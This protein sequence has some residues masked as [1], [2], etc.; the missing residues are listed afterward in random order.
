VIGAASNHVIARG[1]GRSYGD[2]A[3]TGGGTVIDNRGLVQRSMIDPETGTITLG[4]GVSLDELLR[5]AIPAGY[6]VPVTPGTRQV[7]IGGAIAAD[8]HGKN[9]HVDGSFMD[10]IEALT[11]VTPTGT[12]S[13]SPS[14]DPE[15]F[16]AT[17]GGM[18][19]TGVVVEATLRLMPIET[20]SVLVDTERFDDLDALMDAMVTGDHRYRYS[21]AWVD[22]MTKGA[23]LGRGVLTRGD[24]A[25]ADQVPLDKPRLTPPGAPKL[26]IPF[27]APKGLLNKFSIAA[28]NEAWFRKAPKHRDAEIQ[29]LSTFFHPLDGVS[30]WNRLH[31]PRGFLQ[32]QFVVPDSASAVVRQSMELLSSRSVPS[33]LAVLKRFGEGNSGLLSF[34]SA[35]W[36]LALDIPLGA[37][38][39][40]AVLDELDD[41]IA[42]AGGRIYLAKDSRLSP[43]LIPTMYP[44]FEQFQ[45]VCDRVDPAQK[46]GSD[47]SRRLNLRG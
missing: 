12:F 33:F 13:I 15:L 35:G 45:A 6:F 47:L 8:I 11:L 23:R 10:H 46:L 25:A 38:H 17:A 30:M 3:Q 2:P 42:H 37:G 44:K 32:Y 36:T 16:W 43:H 29:S 19:L 7:T 4:S 18:G 14:H 21:V 31:G 22:C 27:T 5:E 28:F 1:L 26:A 9:H 41:L 39:A 40:S 24:H 34:P 20:S